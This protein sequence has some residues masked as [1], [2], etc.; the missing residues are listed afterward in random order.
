L[1]RPRTAERLQALRGDLP[2]LVQVERGERGERAHARQAR[3]GHL[4]AALEVQVA[5]AAQRA[6]RA[7]LVAWRAHGHAS[8]PSSACGSP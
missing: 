4:V 5:Q 7:Q 2:A 3:V 6:Q 1:K 8:I